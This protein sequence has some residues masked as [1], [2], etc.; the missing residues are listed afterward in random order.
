MTGKSFQVP[1]EP[2]L[3][4]L[5]HHWR[6]SPQ[7][8]LIRDRNYEK[9]ATVSE[10][11][12]D[13]LFQCQFISERLDSEIHSQ[14]QELTHDVFIALLARPGYEFA[15]LF[16]AIY[17]LGAVA[18][19]LAPRLFAEEVKYF[20]DSSNAVLL[21]ASSAMGGRAVDIS[22]SLGVNAYVL[23]PQPM[24]ETDPQF[25]LCRYKKK[26]NPEKG[27]SLLYTSGTTGLP[28]GVLYS[29]RSACIGAYADLM[30]L[31]SRD[32]WLQQPALAL[33]KRI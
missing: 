5:F 3:I 18:V 23:E 30:G 9:E 8:I 31:S 6:E 10:F 7:H 25:V 17:S 15:V 19:P 26:I 33:E 2:F 32:T 22:T 20:L 4:E 29:R 28:K 13:I 21:T 12:Q 27:F 11:L 16:F 14:L 1:Q 24:K